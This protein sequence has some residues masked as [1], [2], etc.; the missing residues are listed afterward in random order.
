[1]PQRYLYTYW[2]VN[3]SNT[4]NYCPLVAVLDIPTLQKATKMKF[5]FLKEFKTKLIFD[6]GIFVLVDY[7]L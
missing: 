1:M 3:G 6:T 4:S 5:I 7:G 2:P